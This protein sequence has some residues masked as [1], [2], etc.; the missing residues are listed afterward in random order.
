M[1]SKLDLRFN[2]ELFPEISLLFNKIAYDQRGQFNELVSALSLPNKKNLD[3]WVQ[4]PASRNTFA[5]PFFHHY[6]CLCLLNNLVEE[7]SFEF[8]K[9]IVDSPVFRKLVEKLLYDHGVRNCITRCDSDVAVIA[10]K[11]LKKYLSTPVLFL[12]KLI[13]FVVARLTRRSFLNLNPEKPV[14]LVDTFLTPDYLTPDRWYGNLW[15]NL[16][17]EMRAETFFVPTLVGAPISSLYSVYNGLRL[18]PGKFLIKEDYLKLNDIIYAFRHKQRLEDLSIEPLC[19]FGCDISGLVREELSTN[20]DYLAVIESILT[21]RFIWRLSQSGANVRLAIDWF[22]GQVVDK[23]WNLALKEYFPGTKRIGYRAFESYP[24]YLCSYPIS[25][26]READV[27]PDTMAVQGRGA[28]ATVREF[29]PDLDVMLIPS[30]RSKHVWEF[31]P[32]RRTLG[33]FAILVA[34]PISVAVSARMIRQLIEVHRSM[35]FQDKDIEYVLKPHPTVSIDRI[36]GELRVSIPDGFLFSEEKSFPKMLTNAD[37]LITE[38]SS[39]CL[40]A[41]ACGIPVIIME[42]DG[43][44][45]YDPVPEG[46]P[47][48]LYIRGRTQRQLI[49][50]IQYFAT[51]T[52]ENLE[53]LKS[54]GNKLRADYFEP[55]TKEGINRFMNIGEGKV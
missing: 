7:G 20:S 22:E 27:I 23:A 39:A 47:D 50:G 28:I 16:T 2:G 14:T 30:F 32:H 43:G 11:K 46:I 3:W 29:L 4:G 17:E 42:N 44:L 26:E 33:K 48:R 38:A 13:Q 37:L 12:K 31:N 53:L 34:L 52:S 1:E 35:D 8:K 5:S 6:C 24:F 15:E 36:M 45:T 55:I 40:E 19:V 41:M 21:H 18:G 54:M 49:D 51:L 25:I 10:K 9:V